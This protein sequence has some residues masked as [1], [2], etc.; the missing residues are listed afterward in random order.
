MASPMT[1]KDDHGPYRARS[2][3]DV[4]G[5]R[6]LV[7]IVYR[8]EYND[9][10]FEESDELLAEEIISFEPD[11]PALHALFCALADVELLPE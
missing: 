7:G 3:G 8:D 5:Y 10:L 6:S 9:G 2:V 4:D 11:D 1:T